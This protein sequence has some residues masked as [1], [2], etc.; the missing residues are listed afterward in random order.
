MTPP[1]A[2]NSSIRRTRDYSKTGCTI[3]RVKKKKCDEKK[4][5]CSFC[6]RN[7]HACSWP[8]RYSPQAAASQVQ[9]V[10]DL[11]DLSASAASLTLTAVERQHAYPLAM[12]RP[13]TVKGSTSMTLGS[14]QQV[15]AMQYLIEA[16]HQISRHSLPDGA[17]FQNF[18][19]YKLGLPLALANQG[20][21][22]AFLAIS[23]AHLGRQ[24]S[25][26]QPEAVRFYQIS[27]KKMQ[28]D[29]MA[30]GDEVPDE[31]LC[32][33]SLSFAWYEVSPPPPCRGGD[34]SRTH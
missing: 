12:D 3:C 16:G 17:E 2:A 34:A 11:D 20:H 18:N 8:Q 27:V 30:L 21:L 13:R 29:L 26:D 23:L 25:S 32:M 15:T 28:T 6:Q 10:H 31:L 33:T 9:A 5:V 4:P 14:G 7:A 1:T 22:E 24:T 19:M